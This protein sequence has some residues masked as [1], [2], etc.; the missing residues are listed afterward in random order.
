MEGVGSPPLSCLSLSQFIPAFLTHAPSRQ[1]RGGRKVESRQ[2]AAKKHRLCSAF[3]FSSISASRFDAGT[4]LSSSCFSPLST[5]CTRH[6]AELQKIRRGGEKDTRS[7]GGICCAVASAEGNSRRH[8]L[9]REEFESFGLLR[10]RRRLSSGKRTRARRKPRPRLSL[11]AEELTPAM[12][13]ARTSFQKKPD[14]MAGGTPPEK[15]RRRVR[16]LSSSRSRNS[17][18][19]RRLSPLGLSSSGTQNPGKKGSRAARLCASP[20]RWSSSCV[21]RLFLFCVVFATLAVGAAPSSS[22]RRP[23]AGPSARLPRGSTPF[24]SQAGNLGD[25]TFV[26]VRRFQTLGA[27]PQGETRK[28]VCARSIRR[29]FGTRDCVRHAWTPGGMSCGA[30]PCFLPSG[31]CMLPQASFLLS[32]DACQAVQR[33][34]SLRFGAP[35]VSSTST[36]RPC[37][38]RETSCGSP[39]S[40]LLSPPARWPP[41]CSPR[42]SCPLPFSSLWAG[43]G[44]GACVASEASEAGVSPHESSQRTACARRGSSSLGEKLAAFSRSLSFFGLHFVFTSVVTG[45]IWWTALRTH[46]GLTTLALSRP[47]LACSSL[48]SRLTSSFP[49]SSC[50]AASCRQWWR[51]YLQDRCQRIAWRINTLWGGAFSWLVG[52]QPEVSGAENLPPPEEN[53]IFV[54]NHCSLMDVAYIAAAVP[55]CLR[56]IAKVELLSAPVVGLA[57]RLSGCPTVDRDSP[58]SH[59]ALFREALRL[60]KRKA[61]PQS[62]AVRRL[63]GD[64]ERDGETHNAR[65]E[66]GVALVAFPEGTRSADGRLRPFDK[67]GV[68]RLA[69]QTRVRV[70]PITV[71]GTHLLLPANSLFPPGP[72]PPGT[73]RVVVHPPLSSADK[74]PDELREE[75][76]RAIAAALPPCQQPLPSAKEKEAATETN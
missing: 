36:P 20:R 54:A 2:V 15:K 31:S 59:L 11:R 35:C 65:G 21:S 46:Q 1:K 28:R 8:L 72:P 74:T 16:A 44:I 30:L 63:A 52:C 10:M 17:A 60:L 19:A 45:G 56:F 3:A 55:R 57:L 69:R 53:V 37:S 38:L 6:L 73:L 4:S 61:P 27:K 39:E 9:C 51:E 23:P 67:G 48:F 71:V 25:A 50:S 68:F 70:V 47:A 34:R 26:P 49:S 75:A 40:F 22:P 14:D 33:G 76:W 12:E 24:V 7:A 5:C 29:S 32:R 64:A 62:T 66:E 58:T 43:N 13:G 18:A 42:S 41:L